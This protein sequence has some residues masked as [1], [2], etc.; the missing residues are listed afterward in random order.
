M[1]RLLLLAFFLCP[2]VSCLDPAVEDKPSPLPE[3]PQTVKVTP[4]C[5]AVLLVGGGAVGA[6]V[7]ATVLP[8]LMYIAG[9]SSGGVL[10]N[11]FAAS[12][13]STMPLVAQGSLFALLQS[14]AAGGV[15]STVVISAAAIGSTSGMLVM[16]RTCSAI[17][18]VPAGS[19]EAALVRTLVTVYAQLQPLSQAVQQGLQDTWKVA[20]ATATDAVIAAHSARTSV[21][22][23]MTGHTLYRSLEHATRYVD[24]VARPAGQLLPT[25]E[26]VQTM[27]ADIKQGAGDGGKRVKEMVA[28]IRRFVI[29]RGREA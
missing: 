20:I 2:L 13:Q 26:Q 6:A 25:K 14:A 16:E 3:G 4:Q 9:F 15:G 23:S 24:H 10:A 1:P 28:S 11:S 8:A 18:N 21:A 5:A 17:D 7:A 22:K 12:W 19:A 27:M 29:N